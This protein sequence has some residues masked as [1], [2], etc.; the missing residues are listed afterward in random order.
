MVHHRKGLSLGFEPRQDLL[1]IHPRFDQFDRDL[2]FDRFGLLGQ[3]DIAHAAFADP[4]EQF[5]LARDE[6]ANKM[7]IPVG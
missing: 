3:P 2:P 5:V 6:R 4:F 7:I 1:R